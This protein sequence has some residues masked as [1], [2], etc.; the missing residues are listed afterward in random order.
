VGK[1]GVAGAHTTQRL[2]L[3]KPWEGS[4]MIGQCLEPDPGNLAVRDFRG[5]SGNVRQGET[6]TP[7]CNR[8]S[9]NGNPSPTA[10][11]ARFLSRPFIMVQRVQLPPG[12]G[13]PANRKRVLHVAVATPSLK[14][15]Q[16]VPKPRGSLDIINMLEP[17]LSRQ[18]GQHLTRPLVAR[19]RRSGRG[20]GTGQ[21]HRRDRLGT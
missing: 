11:R 8:K 20:L 16:Q 13:Q 9:G 10:R 12:K 19:E 14:R 1:P 18:Q 6:V 17:L 3:S 15:R 7:S 4:R 21:R 2:N 5:A